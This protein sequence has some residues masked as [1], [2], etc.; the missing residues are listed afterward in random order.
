MKKF[1]LAAV[2]SAVASTAFA[3]GKEAPV[4]TPEVMAPVESSGTN[5]I[6]PALMVAAVVAIAAN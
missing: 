4:T 1:A 2:L 3:G 5:W 6:I